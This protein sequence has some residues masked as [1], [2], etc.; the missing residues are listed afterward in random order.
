MFAVHRQQASAMSF[1]QGG[2]KFAAHDERLFVG[3]SDG[4]ACFESGKGT[5]K[6]GTSNDCRK[7]NIDF[8]TAHEI[9]ESVMSKKDFD[10]RGQLCERGAVGSFIGNDDPSGMLLNVPKL[11]GKDIRLTMDGEQNGYEPTFRGGND[12]QRAL[13]NASTGTKN[14]NASRKGGF[15][16]T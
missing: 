12:F 6:T 2:Q 5:G 16:H 9:A 4:L 3:K 1:D 7:N 14:G 11:F 15:I 8:G 10:V 13:S